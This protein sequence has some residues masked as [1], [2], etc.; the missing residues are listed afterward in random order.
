VGEEAESRKVRVLP[1]LSKLFHICQEAELRMPDDAEAFIC[2]LEA[3]AG[4]QREEKLNEL[5]GTTTEGGASSSQDAGATYPIS[6]KHAEMLIG[7]CTGVRCSD[8]GLPIPEEKVRAGREREIGELKLFDV[9]EF[10]PSSHARGKKQVR[11]RW[12]ERWKK[13][14]CRSRFVAMEIAYDLRSDTFAGTPPIAVTRWLISDAATGEEKN[15]SIADITCAF[16]HA[17]MEG[18]DEIWLILPP[19]MGMPGLKAKLR[20]AL[21][22]TRRASY[23]WGEF[24]SDHMTAPEPKGLGFQRLKGC[25]QLYWHQQRGL[26]SVVHG[27]DF[28]SSGNEKAQRWLAE[29]MPKHFKV[30]EWTELGPG[31][32]LEGSFLNRTIV[33]VPG[34]GYEYHPDPRHTA[35]L[36]ESLG[37]EGAKPVA[38]PAVRDGGSARADC[39]D[40]LPE[41]EAR[42][43]VSETGRVIYLS[44]DRYDIQYVVR[45]LAQFLS[46]PRKLDFLRLKHLAKYLK[47]T[48]GWCWV[49]PFQSEEAGG[50]L[51]AVSDSDWAADLLTRKSVN[52]GFL[53]AGAHV[54]EHW[55][56]GQQVVAL[57]SGE[58]EFYANGKAIAHALFF[59]YLMKEMGRVVKVRAGTDTSAARGVLQR[60]G[61]GRIRHLQTRFLWV[62]ERVKAKE[63]EEYAEKGEDTGADIG[64]K[65][66]MGERIRTLSLALGLGPSPWGT[67][68]ATL[69]ILLSL[70][71]AKAASPSHGAVQA[72]DGGVADDLRGRPGRA[73]RGGGLRLVERVAPA[74]HH[75]GGSPSRVGRPTARGPACVERAAAASSSSKQSPGRRD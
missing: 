64:T 11:C 23:L 47:G 35:R 17:S 56:A 51:L 38:A 21:Y 26:K 40:L 28:L 6:L 4:L 10:W 43:Y 29:Q 71:G 5:M 63:V 20:C 12:V 18:E 65:I 22:G 53:K 42:T 61:P 39:Q 24:V 62:Q 49:F 75:R 66:L 7:D 70:Q 74:P 25:P 32:E 8:T 13:G 14:A 2:N 31:R 58:A 44:I 72:Q 50:V 54:W 48:V 9:W 52:S 67:K 41:K 45:L 37:L 59:L 60:A 15:I 27:D 69:V 16:F 55:C 30:K 73:H 3:A 1:D 46:Q 36:L 34:R 19:G 33:F 57:S 68:I